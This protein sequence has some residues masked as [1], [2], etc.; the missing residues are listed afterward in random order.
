MAGLIL[1]VLVFAVAG[2][3][4]RLMPRLPG[5]SERSAASQNRLP[6][7]I[8]GSRR[9]RTQEDVNRGLIVTSYFCFGLALLALSWAI[10]LAVT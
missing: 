3:L 9:L 7:V 10:A 5:W 1:L 6:A 4:A 2:L 8:R